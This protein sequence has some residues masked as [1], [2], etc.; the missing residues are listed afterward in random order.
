MLKLDLT[1]N[2]VK[3]GDILAAQHLARLQQRYPT[4]TPAPEAYKNNNACLCHA[5]A[6]TIPSIA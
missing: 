3:F 1:S 4:P 2:P 6:P 5:N